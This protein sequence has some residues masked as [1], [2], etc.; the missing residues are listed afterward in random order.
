MGDF[1]D[2][3]FSKGSGKR[4]FEAL[5]IFLALRGEVDANGV[6]PLRP[7]ESFGVKRVLKWRG[8]PGVGLLLR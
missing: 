8:L 4:I 2:K 7:G 6:L 3:T 1:F 5:L